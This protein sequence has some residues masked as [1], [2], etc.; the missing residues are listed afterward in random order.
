MEECSMRLGNKSGA[1]DLRPQSLAM[2]DELSSCFMAV[3]CCSSEPNT[4]IPGWNLDARGASALV[5]PWSWLCLSL[6]L[7]NFFCLD[8]NQSSWNRS[9]SLCSEWQ[10]LLQYIWPVPGPH[11]APVTPPQETEPCPNSAF[12]QGFCSIWAHPLE[13]WP[14]P[15]WLP[16]A[17]PLLC[18]VLPH[19]T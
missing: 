16:R 7:P 14:P 4:E 5:L 11:L 12:C 19:C 3:F 13:P 6:H 10:A 2:A 18:P 15:A 8:Y 1:Q 9:L 17:H